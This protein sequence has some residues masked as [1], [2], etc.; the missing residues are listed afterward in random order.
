MSLLIEG[1][2]AL[3]KE[4]TQKGVARRIGISESLLSRI[5]SGERQPSRQ[6][7]AAI[8]RAYPELSPRVSLFLLEE[9]PIGNHRG[10]IGN[11]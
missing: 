6:T 11:R 7:L 4:N 8:V 1:L 2:R 9:V 3:S 5:L 10:P